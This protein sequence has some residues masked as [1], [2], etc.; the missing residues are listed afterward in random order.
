MPRRRSLTN[1]LKFWHTNQI[2]TSQSLKSFITLRLLD[3]RRRRFFQEKNQI[4]RLQRRRRPNTS[5][6][7]QRTSTGED[8]DVSISSTEVDGS[9]YQRRERQR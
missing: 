4:W 1:R 3:L 2:S 6:S 5:G 8:D 9:G 7:R